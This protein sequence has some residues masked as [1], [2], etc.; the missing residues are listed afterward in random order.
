MTL[1]DTG[2]GNEGRWT[3]DSKEIFEGRP[4]RQALVRSGSQLLRLTWLAG[5]PIRAPAGGRC[6]GSNNS[7]GEREQGGRPGNFIS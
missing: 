7:L 1:A 4:F 3:S 2:E 5:Q 6:Q